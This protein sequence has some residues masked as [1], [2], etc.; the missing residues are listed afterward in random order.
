MR[1]ADTLRWGLRGM[2]R[3]RLRAALTILGIMIGTAA[4][5]ALVSQTQ[6]I[7]ESINNQFRK[8]GPNTL[9]IRPAAQSIILTQKD[10]N[11]ISQMPG[12]ELAI[13]IVTTNVRVYGSG[14][15]RS[16]QLV[17]VDPARFDELIPG[18]EISQGRLFQTISYSELLVGLNVYQP[19][20]LTIPFAS[21][22][23][24]VTV[25][26][27]TSAQ[28]RKVMDIVG[29]LERYGM[30]AL[31][32]VDDSIFMP[33]GGLSSILGTNRYSAIFV[34]TTDPSLVDLVVDTLKA[35]Y[36]TSLNVLTIR[37]ITQVVDTITGMLSVLLGSIA[38]ISLFVAGVGIT[39]IMFVSVVER[40]REIG[41]LKATGFKNSEVLRIFLSEAALL[42]LIGGILG[43]LVGTGLSYLIP[44]LLSRGFGMN[45]TS[46][47]GMGF[48]GGFA[49][50][51][52]SYEPLISP[53]MAA[54]V[55]V[56]AVGVSLLAG[57]LPARRASKMDPVVALRHD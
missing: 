30:S 31:L 18:F 42:G 21:L 36:G 43:F 40:T 51:S 10:I 47:T 56:F 27:G 46:N 39:N 3:R 23:Q 38:G 57:L 33:I 49:S 19:Q 28:N 55:L 34:K 16:Y 2:R 50:G 37:Q 14:G 32:S 45:S 5:I 15:T 11:I 41:I 52:L 6:G 26:F 7:S 24:A 35:T 1:T 48:G 4:V 20:D 25:Q 53:E 12:V 13:P 44:I 17:G 9:T 8:L 29:V 22:G 54:F